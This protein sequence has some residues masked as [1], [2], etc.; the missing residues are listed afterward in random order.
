MG[1]RRKICFSGIG[2]QAVLEGI[3]MKNQDTW[4]VAVR[5]NDGKIAVTKQEDHSGKNSVWKKIPFVRGVFQFVDSLR[6]GMKSLNLSAEYFAE[7]EDEP[8][9]ADKVGEKLFGD[10]AENVLS[11]VTV[12]FSLVF[13][14]ALFMVLPYFLASLLAKVI[15]DDSLLAL[16]EGLIRLLIFLIYIIAITAVKDIRRVYQYHGAEHKCINCIE[17]GRI[18]DVSNVRKSSRFHKRC[19]TSFLLFVMII[20][21]ILF[22]FIKVDQVW[23]R[24]VLRL[25]LIPVIAGI[26][27]EF[28]RFAGKSDNVISNLLSAPGLWLQRLTTKE[29]DDEMIEVAIAAVEAVF[30]WKDYLKKTFDYDVDAYLGLK[31]YD[32]DDPEEA[33]GSDDMDVSE[34]IA[35]MEA[36]ALVAEETEASEDIDE[37]NNIDSDLI[38]DPETADTE[39][40]FDSDMKEIRF[41]DE[42]PEEN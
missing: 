24:L 1:R 17:H 28:I 40:D 10:G 41:A 29:P 32:L 4:A 39:T 15:A 9:A 19:G 26:S 6:L 3:M 30:D 11:V 18:L 27:Y 25:L 14:I 23:L 13:A 31:E 21:I 12:C 5:K 33:D 38:M 37:V 22:F 20:S 34:E 16:F 35:A 42:G 8:T 36:Q 7:E 2:G